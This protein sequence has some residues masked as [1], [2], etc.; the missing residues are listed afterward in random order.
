MTGSERGANR[1]PILAADIRKAHSDSIAA[2]KLSAESALA[3][4][5]ALNEAKSLAKHGD[6]LPFLA[7]A[8][9]PERTAQRYMT[10]AKSGLKS[11]TVSLLGGVTPAL[12]FLRIRDR[13]C[14]LLDEAEAAAL[15]GETDDDL[16]LR[17]LEDALDLFAELM[18]MFPPDIAGAQR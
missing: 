7:E 6:W 14:R 9:V 12:R 16:L 17:P 13:A 18:A 10:L 3:A 5:E 1:L 8:G 11:D 2:S 4:G 15:R